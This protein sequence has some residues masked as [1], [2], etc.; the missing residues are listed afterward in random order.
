MAKQG[1]M[2]KDISVVE[3]KWES[4]NVEIRKQW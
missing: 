4:Q 2:N 3:E 1:E